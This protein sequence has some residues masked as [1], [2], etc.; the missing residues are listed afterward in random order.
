FEE[1]MVKICLKILDVSN[2]HLRDPAGDAAARRDP[3]YVGRVLAAMVNHMDDFGVVEGRW[4][5]NFLGGFMPTHWNGSH[6]ILR[7]W[8]DS[9]CQPVKYGQCW[10]F[11]GVL[12]SVL[13]LLGIPSRV[14]T[15]FKSAHDTNGNLSIDSY[16]SE[17]GFRELESRDSIW[18]FHVWVEG[19]MKRPDL[20]ADGKYDGWQVLDPTPQET[21]DGVYCCGPAPVA[22]VLNGD[23]HLEYDVP[24]VKMYSDAS[25]IGQ[26]ISTKSVGSNKRLNVT[27]AYKHTEGTENERAVFKY[28]LEKLESEPVAKKPQL[29]LLFEEV[30][31]PV[32]GEDVRL[33]LVVSGDNIHPRLL[34]IQISVQAMTYNGSPAG[35]IQSE[36]V[37]ETLHPGKDVSIPITV[38]YSAYQ[39]HMVRG[40]SMN[41]FAVVTDQ[42]NPD[43]VYLADDVVVLKNPPISVKVLGSVRLHSEVMAE[44]VFMNPVNETLQDCSLTLSGSGLLTDEEIIKLQNLPASSRFII[45]F[46]FVPYK[47]GERSLL[48]DFD[49]SSFRDIKASCTVTVEP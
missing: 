6:A 35:N 2:Q 25:L 48:V 26:N 32:N 22:A 9:G 19:W 30:S 17:E 36:R 43:S 38:L 16:F 34:S 12:C 13:R 45:R 18:N 49:S 7:R 42:Q 28:A 10:V 40:G 29:V 37:E 21:S 27:A 41:V 24:F 8:Y 15:N 20:G 14:I 23:T 4:G 46:S 11:A 31:K 47:S 1:D 39:D 44:V 5:R 3:A 33:K